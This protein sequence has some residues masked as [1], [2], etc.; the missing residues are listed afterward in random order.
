MSAAPTLQSVLQLLPSER[1]VAIGRDLEVGVPSA[2]TRKDGIIQVLADA[3]VPL[4]AVL[5]GLGRD[6][7][8]AACKAH[9]L[10]ATSRLR[11][12]LA[13]QLMAGL[14]KTPAPRP[15][16]RQ[17]PHKGDIVLVRHRQYLVEYVEEVVDR[18]THLKLVCL[19]D[20]AQGRRLDVLWELELGAT[21]L[22]PEAHGLG[23]VKALDEPRT[24]AAYLHALRW[25]CVS[26]KDAKL[27]QSP[28]R[29]GIRIM[30]HQL[31]AL[32][33]ALEL[34][35][36]NLFIADDVGLG[37]TIEAGLVLQELV[38]R[39]R[40]DF[41]LIV[42]PA[43]VML[44]WREEMERRFG[45]YFEMYSRALVQR[46]RQERGFGINPWATHTRFIVSYQTLRRPEH[47]EPLLAHLGDRARKSMLIMDEAHTAAPASSTIYAVDSRITTVIQDVAPRFENR[48]FLSAT[49]HNGHSNSFSSLMEMLDSRRFTRGIPTEDP[50]ALEPVMVR[51]L[52]EDLRQLGVDAFPKRRVGTV[53]LTH[54]G[55]G[56]SSATQWSDGV[57]AARVLCGPGPDAEL[58]LSSM[59]AEYTQLMKPEKGAGRLVFIS[60]QKRLLSGVNAFHRTVIKHA[61]GVGKGGATAL[62]KRL[63]DEDAELPLGVNDEDREDID[64]E[65]DE[66]ASRTLQSPSGRARQLLEDM[67]RVAGQHREA[68]DAKMLALLAWLRD[69]VCEGFALEGRPKSKPAW[70]D[71]R[72]LVFTE[73]GHTR[74]YL[75]D[76]LRA[77]CERVPSG[78]GRVMHIHGGMSE[79]ARAEVQHAFNAPPSEHPVRILVA[80]DAA[81]EGINLQAHCAD[82]FHWDVPWNPARMEQRNGRIDRTLQP[83]PEVRCMYFS[84]AQRT[85]DRVLDVLVEKVERIQRE[86]GSV[87]RVVLENMSAVLE[88]G[89][90]LESLARLKDTEDEARARSKRERTELDPQRDLKKVKKEIDDASRILSESRKIMEFDPAL[91]RDALDV[92]LELSRAKRL[93]A[94]GTLKDAAGTLQTFQVPEL[95]HS[96]RRTLDKLRP[97]RKRDE[98]FW[99]WREHAPLPVVFEPP[100]TMRDD[101]VHLHLSHPFVQRVMARFLAQGFSAQDL[102]RV[103]VVRNK[104]D[105][106]PRVLAFARLTLFGHG[107]LR[108]HDQLLAVAAE[109]N[110]AGTGNHLKPFSVEEDRKVV[111]ELEVIL[112]EAPSLSSV[113]KPIKERM[114]A[115]A[116]GDYSALWPH[117]EAEKDAFDHD[118]TRK[119]QERGAREAADL[120][121]ILRNQKEAITKRLRGEQ[122]RLPGVDGDVS[123]ED[124]KDRKRE[125]AKFEDDRKHMEQR[126]IDLDTEI[127]DEPIELQT[128]YKVV[129]R[130]LVPVGMVYLWPVTR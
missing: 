99:D 45:L 70:K 37:K 33:K 6:E 29:A 22:H 95:S 63:D 65:M 8:W 103:T 107:A 18:P 79:E 106:V 7:L 54:D 71:T 50:S 98:T 32:K 51:R 88:D 60:L 68:P 90:T 17:I 56:W 77:F 40:V 16:H 42:C 96:W 10:P 85:E 74:G 73:Y 24:F 75:V 124:L 126:L 114:L 100:Q 5:R 2:K 72:V 127:R 28:F 78:E 47:R 97:A 93:E 119:L 11:S 52:K 116:K 27:F 89:I 35:R 118:A 49:P 80:T 125:L 105:D 64:G 12:D 61:N 109:W 48:L 66:A 3:Q 25:N 55:N 121:R 128:R 87:G 1:I 101:V 14:S 23:D 102:S 92:G 67:L 120:T 129:L 53:S 59:L 20:D 38:L 123:A 83:E 36:V 130:R 111:R 91:L 86:L 58:Q 31:T 13:A 21:I 39:Q 9:G 117:L 110:D 69:N 108:L 62:M 44:Q 34:P 76:Q 81:R 4:D 94:A 19:D 113:P 112:A 84:Y 57:K 43:S 82:L 122:F 30:N 26:A 46:R 104:H 115:A 41:T 15:R